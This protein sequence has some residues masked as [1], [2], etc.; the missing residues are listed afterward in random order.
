MTVRVL[1]GMQEFVDFID[2]L[3]TPE[4][5]V[6]CSTYLPSALFSKSSLGAFF[7]DRQ[8]ADVSDV[9]QRLWKYSRKMLRYLST[10][11]CRLLIEERSL[12][13]FINEGRVHVA[14]PQFEVSHRTRADV[15]GKL[16][17]L[18]SDDIAIVSPH[19]LPFVFRLVPPHGVLIDVAQNTT[20]QKVQGIW[21]EDNNAY[22]AFAIEAIRLTTDS[23][24]MRGGDLVARLSRAHDQLSVGRLPFWA[25]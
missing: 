15:L 8:D 18:A 24:A 11:R 12:A 16:R 14:V 6:I 10:G 4:G 23:K 5:G 2:E 9:T 17:L 22:E 21:I 3:P 25:S 7:T 13:A 19:P 1:V 20:E